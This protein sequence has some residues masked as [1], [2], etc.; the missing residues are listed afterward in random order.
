MIAY[1]ICFDNVVD[2]KLLQVGDGDDWLQCGREAVEGALAVVEVA[3]KLA[4]VRNFPRIEARL[5]SRLP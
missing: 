3:C 1:V 2:D 4:V 5:T